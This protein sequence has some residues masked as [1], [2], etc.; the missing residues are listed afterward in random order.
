MMS[1]NT[2]SGNEKQKKDKSK[3]IEGRLV[4]YSYNEK[5]PAEISQVTAGRNAVL[6][7]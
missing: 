2:R 4:N 7:Q 6:K 1:E 5:K 3:K